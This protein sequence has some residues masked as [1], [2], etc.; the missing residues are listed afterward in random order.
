MGFAQSWVLI[1]HGI[2]SAWLHLVSNWDMK[3]RYSSGIWVCRH[4][5]IDVDED[6]QWEGTWRNATTSSSEE[7]T[8]SPPT[9]ETTS[10]RPKRSKRST[11]REEE[12][13]VLVTLAGPT[14]CSINP[15]YALSSYKTPMNSSHCIQLWV[16]L[17]IRSFLRRI[18]TL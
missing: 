10:T 13:L 7:D 17:S 4:R 3:N 16:G 1:L 12:D 9:Q 14:M 8:N 6:H 5:D 18:Q 15:W 11:V 2:L